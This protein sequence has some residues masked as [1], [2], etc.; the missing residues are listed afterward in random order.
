MSSESEFLFSKKKEQPLKIIHLSD[1]RVGQIYKFINGY[2]VKTPYYAEVIEVDEIGNEWFKTS[3]PFHRTVIMDSQNW[4][5]HQKRM[6]L[7]GHK[8]EFGYLLL[9]QKNL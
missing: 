5:Y 7:M 8:K 6:I 9:N 2:H 3:I 1:V 4:T